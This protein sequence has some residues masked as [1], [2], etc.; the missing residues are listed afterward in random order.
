MNTYDAVKRNW[1]W[2]IA[3]GVLLIILGV[4]AIGTAV[5]ATLISVL[6]FG[7]LLFIGGIFQ[8]VHAFWVRT[9]SGMALQLFIGILNIIVGL[10]IIGNPGASALALTLLMAA[11]FIVGGVFR[12]AMS[13]D[14]HAPGRG[15]GIVSGIIDIILGVLIWI[16]WPTTAF[17]V[18]GLFIG[19]DLIFT[20]WWFITLAMLGRHITEPDVTSPA[21]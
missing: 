20:G 1:G 18:I 4:I 8:I 21:V 3:L 13:L 9:W 12:V 14:V 5:A 7:C 19:I 17:W 6:I 16:H 2:F 11:F 10:L 15:W